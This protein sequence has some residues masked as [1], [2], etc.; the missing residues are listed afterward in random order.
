MNRKYD[1]QLL[2]VIKNNDYIKDL[3]N[4]TIMITGASGLIGRYYI[5]IIMKYNV[6]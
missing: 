2:D 1:K 3:S 4:K 5:D 6:Y